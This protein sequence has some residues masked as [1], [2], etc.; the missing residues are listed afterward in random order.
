M[1]RSRISIQPSV[2]FCHRKNFAPFS[3]VVMSPNLATQLVK[4]DS[5]TVLKDFEEIDYV[6]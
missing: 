6:D 2:A 4:E 3:D 5:M 1:S